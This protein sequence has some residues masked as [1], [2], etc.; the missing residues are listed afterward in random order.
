MPNLNAGKRFTKLSTINGDNYDH[1]ENDKSL[2]V[3][4]EVAIKF[5]SKRALKVSIKRV[6]GWE[7]FNVPAKQAMSLGCGDSS[8]V[9]FVNTEH[10]SFP[11][12][13]VRAKSVGKAVTNSQFSA[14]DARLDA[15]KASLAERFVYFPEITIVAA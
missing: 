11:R 2:N 13:A 3:G 8:V 7:D 1:T 10:A 9:N 15:A 12:V 14:L 5:F 4:D 6:D